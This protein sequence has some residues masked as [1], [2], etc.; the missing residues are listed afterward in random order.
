MVSRPKA[1]VGAN[2][3]EELTKERAG[4]YAWI[5]GMFARFKFKF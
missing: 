2:G 4:G 3:V 1:F 5:V